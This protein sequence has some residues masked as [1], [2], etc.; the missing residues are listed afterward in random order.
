MTFEFI[1]FLVIFFR[2]LLL[3]FLFPLFASTFF[4]TKIKI[5]LSL[6]LALAFTPIVNLKINTSSNVMFLLSSFFSDFL[7]FSFLSLLFRF[8][9]G[10]LQLGGELVGFQMGF[11]IS[12]TFDPLSGIS[13]PILSQ[14]IYLMFILFFFAL[15]IHH[16]LIYFVIK[17]FEFYTP[18]SAWLRKDLFYL[19]LKKSSLIFDIAVKV[20]A[21]LMILMLLINIVLAVIGRVIPQINVLFVSLPLTLGIGLLFF[22]LMLILLPRV[23]NALFNEFFKFLN[24]F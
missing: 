24:V 16:H 4:P 7:L 19:L 22:G 18:G 15:D 6:I 21:P 13:M 10:G 5:A 11:G 20:L 17:S 2:F 23:F 14:F 1:S 9:L 8:L 3:F 12:Q